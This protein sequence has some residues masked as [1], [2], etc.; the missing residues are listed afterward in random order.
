[1]KIKNNS[2][3]R[4]LWLRPLQAAFLYSF[5]YALYFRRILALS[6]YPIKYTLTPLK[7]ILG[8]SGVFWNK[9]L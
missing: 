7:W 4:L 8:G 3:R 2:S 6:S 9:V 1:M 5:I